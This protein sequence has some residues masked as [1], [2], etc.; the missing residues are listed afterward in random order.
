MIVIL[1]TLILGMF[2]ALLITFTE[3]DRF[4]EVNPFEPG[5]WMLPILISNAIIFATIILYRKNKLPQLLTSL[6][7]SIFKF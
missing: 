5:I 4:F 1:F 6:F 3:K 2:P 7:K